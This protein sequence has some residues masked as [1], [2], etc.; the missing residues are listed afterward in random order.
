MNSFGICGWV[1]PWETPR[2]QIHGLHNNSERLSWHSKRFMAGLCPNYLLCKRVSL[3]G[4]QSPWTVKLIM[5]WVDLDLSFKVSERQL[6]L[7]CNSVFFLECLLSFNKQMNQSF[8]YFRLS[9]SVTVYMVCT[10]NGKNS[11]PGTYSEDPLLVRWPCSTCLGDLL[12][13]NN[14]KTCPKTFYPR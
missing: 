5:L 2:P 7:W 8:S 6:N 10:E 3:V 9:L 14:C 13:Q 11:I 4:I 1:K 12:T